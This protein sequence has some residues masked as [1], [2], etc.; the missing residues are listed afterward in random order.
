MTFDEDAITQAAAELNLTPD[1]V[2]AAL[3]VWQAYRKYQKQNKQ[4]RKQQHIR[5]L[6]QKRLE[7]EKRRHPERCFCLEEGIE[8]KRDPEQDNIL[9][10]VTRYYKYDF[11]QKN[12]YQEPVYACSRCGKEYVIV[13]AIA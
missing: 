5:L 6:D 2:K 8:V 10:Y 7:E 12:P 3:E 13:V 11:E 4:Q 1:E 9:R